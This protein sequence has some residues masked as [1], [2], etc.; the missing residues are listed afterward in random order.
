M[1]SLLLACAAVLASQ[2]RAFAAPRARAPRLRHRPLRAERVGAGYLERLSSYSD[3]VGYTLDAPTRYSI[4]DWWFNLQNIGSSSVLERI[5]GHLVA[6]TVWSLV[7]VLCYGSWLVYAQDNEA[8]WVG[9]VGLD[10]GSRADDFD[11]FAP[12]TLSGGILGILLAFR[13]GQSYDRF[14]EG[15][16]VW[17][18]VVNR[19]R[20]IARASRSYAT[21]D[22]DDDVVSGVLLRWLAAFPLALKQHLRGERDVDAFDM[23]LGGER[24]DLESADNLPLAVSYALSAEVDGIRRASDDSQAASQ[25]L[26]WQM[27]SMI[28]DLQDAIGDAEA[29]AGT[30]VPL[31]YSRHTSRLL[32]IWTLGSPIILVQSMPLLLVPP[33]TALLSWMLLATEEIGHIIEEPFGIHDDRPKILPLQRYC[34]IV[35]RDLAEENRLV[36][37]AVAGKRGAAEVDEVADVGG[38]Y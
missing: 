29:I 23:L 21:F 24:R 12:F 6:N 16:Q 26:W 11:W 38:L 10:Y 4:K 2:A 20:A 25:L 1:A 33:A 37:R 27:E 22:D 5:G 31:S 28:L 13:T 7:V 30:P 14:W 8:P 34:D 35:S 9:I 17:A 3:E 18:R 36:E 32:S 15:R 19:V